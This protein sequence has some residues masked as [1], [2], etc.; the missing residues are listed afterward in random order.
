MAKAGL[1]MKPIQARR[2]GEQVA[3]LLKQDKAK[4]Q[5]R[6]EAGVIEGV[7]EDV[8]LLSNTMST[9]ITAR[10]QKKAATQAQNDVAAELASRVMAVRSA[11]KITGQS[12][13]VR[14]ALGVGRVV[15]AK[16]VKSVLAGANM[17]VEAYAK[18]ADAMRA[19]GVLPVD[20]ETM[21]GLA[22]ALADADQAQEMKKVASK[23]STAE[24]AKVQKR[25][26][27]ALMKIIAAAGL[28]FGVTD[29]ERAAQYAALIPAKPKKRKPK[30]QP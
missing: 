30:P 22:N 6:L 20:V 10:V 13:V 25:L 9:A 8:R 4:L 12:A 28:Q 5:P 1:R 29:P 2:A 18:H 3:E 15:S 27:G 19:A 21:T 16:S 17:V 14:K 11:V 26:E 23:L 7:L 24:R